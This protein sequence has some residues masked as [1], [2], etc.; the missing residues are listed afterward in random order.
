MAVKFDKPEGLGV[1]D[2][3]EQ[4]EL[5][6]SGISRNLRNRDRERGIKDALNILKKV[7]RHMD[8]GL[9]DSKKLRKQANGMIAVLT[10][11]FLPMIEQKKRRGGK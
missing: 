10:N 4:I 8:K 5:L 11:N 7:R 9:R 3:Y 2:S 6:L 1:L